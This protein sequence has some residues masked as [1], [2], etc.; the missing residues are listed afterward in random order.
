MSAYSLG[1]LN[2]LSEI[3]FHGARSNL[4][5]L[6]TTFSVDSQRQLQPT[7]PK[8]SGYSKGSWKK[9]NKHSEGGRSHSYDKPNRPFGDAFGGEGHGHDS[10]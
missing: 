1:K 10:S 2:C 3:Q 4:S 8:T 5:R 9:Q 6:P 7:G